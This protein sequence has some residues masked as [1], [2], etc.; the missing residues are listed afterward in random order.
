MSPTRG[1]RTRCGPPTGGRSVSLP[2][3]REG[4]RGADKAGIRPSKMGKRRAIVL[5][6]VHV[7]IAIHVA[8]WLMM[9]MTVSPVE[10]SEAMYTLE[11]G[12]VNAGFIFFVLSIVS[13]L[14]LGR[15]F[16]GWGCHVVA[17]QDLCS[18][19]MK[20]FGVRPKPFRTR[21]LVLAPLLLAIY[22][23]V[24]PTVRREVLVPLAGERWELV[25]P[26]LGEAA[27]RPRLGSELMVE[28]F[29]ATFP[30]WYIAVPFL[31]VCG[32]A[33]VYFLGSK[34]FCTYGCPYGGFFGPADRL[35]PG[36]ILVN[37]NC[38][39]CGHCTAVC[40][41]NVRVHEEVR[42]YGMVVDPGCMKCLDCV[43]VCPN[44][45]LRFGFAAPPVVNR[46]VKGAER[47]ARPKKNYDL[48]LR[49]ELVLGVVFFLLVLAYR[50]M[51]NSVPLLM[52]VGMGA[53]GAFAAWKLF[54][55][56]R[57]PNVRLQSL[58]LRI[59]GR[60]TAAGV[61]FGLLAAGYLGLGAWSGAVRYQLWRANLVYSSMTLPTQTVLS[62]D[63]VPGPENVS[64][65]LDAI[66]RYRRAGP[67]SEGGFGWEHT[68]KVQIRTAWLSAVAGRLDQAEASLLRALHGQAPTE[69]LLNQ[70]LNIMAIRGMP[71]D[72]AVSALEGLLRTHA[73]SAPV[74][75]TLARLFLQLG[76]PDRAAA[77][78]SE[79]VA[80][81]PRHVHEWAV[82]A[83]LLL[84]AGRVAEAD[85]ALAAAVRRFPDVS[86]LRY[87]RSLAAVLSNRPADA[88]VHLKEAIRLDPR[89]A[90]LHR[91][92]ASLLAAV[93]KTGEAQ[94]YL[95][96]AARLE[97]PR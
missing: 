15:F 84:H 9:G 65:A 55:L 52:A 59:K 16:C 2:V 78:A 14:I 45:A 34:G 49:G 8:L 4:S 95:D 72:H 36:R 6:A 31:A 18:W 12:L 68:P 82:A 61:I 41:S 51:F 63:Y 57:L 39:G 62:P 53:I 1:E 54:S 43:S 67:P 35:A 83:E 88:E 24:W 19:V 5:A 58:Q 89:N 60:I 22:M 26:W 11:Q 92:M 94:R 33:T 42:A 7:V 70:L 79:V 20:K 28:D 40:T 81:E 38:E 93:G 17:L 56:V 30:P 80:A 87:F 66:E 71:P 23:F 10:P 29:W 76:N 3:V 27:P 64:R 91:R 73:E 37:D 25:S 69:Q 21:L 90:E 97:G 47:S 46:R 48:S 96:E 86:Q 77:F 32:F 13:T 44:D 50:E 75:L 85:T 74:R